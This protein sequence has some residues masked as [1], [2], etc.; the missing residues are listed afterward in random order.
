MSNTTTTE[1]TQDDAGAAQSAD[2]EPLTPGTTD[3]ATDAAT[4]EDDH[5][6]EAAKYRRRLR[7][8]ETER[9]TLRSQ[10][11]AFHRADVARIAGDKLAR[12]AELLEISRTPLADLLDESGAV[13]PA[14]VAEAVAALLAERPHLAKRRF[15][16]GA[17]GGAIGETPKAAASPTW[18]DAFRR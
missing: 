12:G 5:G 16:G 17:D 2:T 6:K 11:E 7:E 4:T 3:T 1:T 9:D 13:D 10:V 18:S 15:A 8:T 14:K